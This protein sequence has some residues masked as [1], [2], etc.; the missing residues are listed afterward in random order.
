MRF[1]PVSTVQPP[2]VSTALISS[3]ESNSKI[4]P[5]SRPTPFTLLGQDLVLW[6][7]RSSGSWRAFADVCPHR[8]VPL[9]QGRL[10]ADGQLECPY[11]GWRFNGEGR[12][13][14]HWKDFLGLG[15]MDPTFGYGELGVVTNLDVLFR[16]AAACSVV[17]VTPAFFQ[18]SVVAEPL[19]GA[20]GTPSYT[21]E[22]R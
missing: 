6:F 11:H 8:L 19:S 12:Q 3:G 10:S 16:I 20:G 14:S 18:A 1:S 4:T 13:A 7:E 17:I 22:I 5:A 15:I 21:V 2:E 9:S